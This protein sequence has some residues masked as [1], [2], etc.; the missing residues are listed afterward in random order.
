MASS[1]LYG[2]FALGFGCGGR[3][4]LA[5]KGTISKKLWV[6]REKPVISICARTYD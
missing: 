3:I 2:T 4:K 1:A 5:H 6:G